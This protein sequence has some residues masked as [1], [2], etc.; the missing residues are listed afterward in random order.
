[1]SKR[2]LLL[3]SNDTSLIEIFR[4]L[5][6][7]ELTVSPDTWYVEAIDIKYDVAIVDADFARM[8]ENINFAVSQA[9]V[10][11]AI[12]SAQR[13][14]GFLN[15]N[16]TKFY[17]IWV[18]PIYLE[19]LYERIAKAIE[20][21]VLYQPFLTVMSFLANEI[22]KP[23]SSTK[24]YLDVLLMGLAGELNEQQKQFL[25]AIIA[26]TERIDSTLLSFQDTTALKIVFM[27]RAKPTNF[28]EALKY[29]AQ[30]ANELELSIDAKLPLIMSDRRAILGVFE[31]LS[32]IIQLRPSDNR[33]IRI[34][35]SPHNQEEIA[36]TIVVDGFDTLAPRPRQKISEFLPQ[37]TSESVTNT[38]LG[39]ICVSLYTI[40]HYLYQIG[41]DVFFESELG[42]GST[43]YFT[44]PIA[45][46]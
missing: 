28:Y 4:Q 23:V 21:K 18:R 34:S 12:V 41:S 39:T 1:M 33:K 25:N 22:S 36:V 24:G 7:F 14:T 38:K 2:N 42:K 17:D 26:N 44:L 29:F 43:F 15:E 31:G 37:L 27:A 10:A 9:T 8:T 35:A 46:T 40:S 13:L 3:I 16:R 5:E 32:R 45:K 19:L 30:E 6:D 11:F 20:H